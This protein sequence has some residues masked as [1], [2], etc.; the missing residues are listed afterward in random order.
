MRIAHFSDLHYAA[1]TLTEVD[2]CFGFA[3]DRAI[4]AN[5]DV[6]VISGD[7]TDHQLDLHIR[8]VSA[9][10]SQ[11][12]RLADHCPVLMLQGTFSHEPPGTLD[13]FRLLGGRFPVYVADRIGQ[14]ALAGRQWVASADWC[15]ETFPEGT[16]LVMSCL[17]TVNKA[18]LAGLAGVADAA[19]AMGSAISA[20]LAGWGIVNDKA[21]ASGIVTA[22]TGHGTIS[23]CVTEHGVPM[24]GLDHEFTLGAL[25]SAHASAF[26]VG[27]IHKQQTWQRDGRMIGYA[28]SMGRLHYGEVDPKG[29]LLWDIDVNGATAKFIETP[30]R[31]M[32]HL[33]FVGAPDMEAIKKAAAA[34]GG[35]FVR[36]RWEVPEED[37][38]TVDRTAIEA[39]LGNAAEV[40]LEGRILPTVRSR[41]DGILKARTLA[42]KVLKWCEVTG[43]RHEGLVDRL[44]ALNLKDP[45]AIATEILQQ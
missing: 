39:I 29:F 8:A 41:A 11:V 35:A 7:S 17:P 22:G 27:H 30:A 15:F 40:R 43:I 19:Q 32:V 38:D 6:A 4:E 44:E 9:L 2:R 5:V 18:V 42:E 20:V 21:R 34:T 10:A 28:G 25:F 12:R 37:R 26:M 13:V 1:N 33:D 23:G 45:E 3:V 16:Q 31:T 24:A 36:V 14:V